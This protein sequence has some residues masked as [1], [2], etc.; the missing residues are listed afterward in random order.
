MFFTLRN[1]SNNALSGNIPSE[2]AD[3]PRILEM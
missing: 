3:L 1:I 2:L